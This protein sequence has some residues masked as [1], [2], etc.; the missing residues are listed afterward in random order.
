MSAYFEFTLSD[1][2][3]EIYAYRINISLWNV[4]ECKNIYLYKI[5]II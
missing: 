4:H 2:F 3:D 1:F 5:G